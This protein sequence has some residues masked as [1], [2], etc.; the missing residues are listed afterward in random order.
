MENYREIK[1]SDAIKITDFEN[2]PF[3]GWYLGTR[4]ADTKEFGEQTIHRF[5]SL[6]DGTN[7]EFWGFEKFNRLMMEVTPLTLC[8]IIYLGKKLQKD[9]TK[10]YHDMQ[11]LNDITNKINEQKESPESDNDD[12]PF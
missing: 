9:K 6:K 3:E 11:V 4:K 8:K 7:K 1:T 2:K 10:S 12:L 5:K